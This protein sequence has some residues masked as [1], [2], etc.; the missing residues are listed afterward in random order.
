MEIFND[1]N[2]VYKQL[3]MINSMMCLQKKILCVVY[4]F[5]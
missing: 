1:L 2:I 5:G 3:F 4:K